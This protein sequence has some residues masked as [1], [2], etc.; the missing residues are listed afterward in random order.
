MID[1]NRF[2]VFL[3][4]ELN[5][6]NITS[7]ELA[8]KMGIQ[9]KV[10]KKWKTGKKFP[11]INE[12]LRLTEILDISLNELLLEIVDHIDYLKTEND[13][14]VLMGMLYGELTRN[15]KM[16]QLSYIILGFSLLQYLIV[17]VCLVGRINNFIFALLNGFGMMMIFLSIRM[18][19]ILKGEY[20][21]EG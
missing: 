3:T 5:K 20:E 7:Y 9:E 18:Y 2:G 10:I 14:E 15:T 1:S 21:N 13:S 19:R 11:A 4:N 16:V 8:L 12:L 17:L 6:Q